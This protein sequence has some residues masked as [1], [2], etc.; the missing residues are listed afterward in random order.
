[1]L[2]GGAWSLCHFNI[3]WHC[4]VYFA[5]NI[6]ITHGCLKNSPL[7]EDHHRRNV[8]IYFLLISIFCREGNKNSSPIFVDQ[9]KV[10][11]TSNNIKHGGNGLAIR[12]ATKSH[13]PW[14]KVNHHQVTQMEVE[15]STMSAH[16]KRME[17][18]SDH[19]DHS[20]FIFW[21]Y[22]LYSALNRSSSRWWTARLFWVGSIGCRKAS[23][24]S[25]TAGNEMNDP[26]KFG[27]FLGGDYRLDNVSHQVSC[28]ILWC[29]VESHR[30]SFPCIL[31]CFSSSLRNH[32]MAT[33]NC[34]KHGVIRKCQK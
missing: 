21:L 12:C 26:P 33:N 8:N 32:N 30:R 2:P 31:C 13:H 1:M 9:L 24:M 25:S 18:H 5:Q 20:V 10:P 11:S 15:R 6:S 27:V 34:D 22:M 23:P 16:K 17:S 7:V 14:A 29:F 28:W 19:S 3:L 4:R